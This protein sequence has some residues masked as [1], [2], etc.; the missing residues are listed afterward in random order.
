MGGGAARHGHQPGRFNKS[1]TS[2]VTFANE[3]PP[4]FSQ[5]A[6]HL[7]QTNFRW[8][9]SDSAG[10]FNRESE[11]NI[12]ENYFQYSHICQDREDAAGI[13]RQTYPFL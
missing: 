4:D 7:L 12:L 2:K 13:D 3:I 9:V 10:D 6:F 5:A 1:T 11:F 8:I